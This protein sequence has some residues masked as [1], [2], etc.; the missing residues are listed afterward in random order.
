MNYFTKK[1]QKYL[2]ESKNS[3][4][5]TKVV[6]FIGNKILFLLPN[7]EPYVGSLDLPGG[8]THVG[9]EL[10]DG[11]R[12]EVKE[13]T[14]LDIKEDTRLFQKDNITYYY[15]TIKASEAKKIKLSDEH[16]DYKL[17]SLKK[18]E[19]GDYKINPDFLAAVQKAQKIKDENKLDLKDFTQTVILFSI[20]LLLV[21]GLYS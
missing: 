16:L 14:G 1:W 17:M 18:L 7:Y 13:E 9:E 4:F 3:D 8:H 5:V 19:E 10:A 20:L 2:K 21:K 15:T 11:L 6:M 12:R